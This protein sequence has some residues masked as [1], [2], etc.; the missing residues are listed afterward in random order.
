MRYAEG[1]EHVRDKAE[2]RG[3]KIRSEVLYYLVDVTGG[4]LLRT[5]SLGEIEGY[6]AGDMLGEDATDE[7]DEL[8]LLGDPDLSDAEKEELR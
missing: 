3:Y 2:R 4:T 7:D 8:S 6:L 5:D 1:Y